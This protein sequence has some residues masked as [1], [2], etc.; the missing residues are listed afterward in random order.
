MPSRPLRPRALAALCLGGVLALAGCTMNNDDGADGSSGSGQNGGIP[1][2]DADQYAQV[3]L[4]LTS[5]VW[6]APP[7][8]TGERYGCDDLLVPIQTVP[9][10]DADRL[11]VALDFLLADRSGVHGD[12]SLVNAVAASEDT[13]TLTEHRTSGGRETVGFSGNIIV[14]GVCGAQRVRAQLQ[15]TVEAISGR[16]ASIE[17]DGVPLD[18]YLGLAPLEQGEEYTVPDPED[19]AEPTA[20]PSDAAPIEPG[21]TPTTFEPLPIETATT[22]PDW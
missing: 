5:P 4:Y 16:E 9:V 20:D 6:S 13:L 10:K 1:Q 11:A 17:I 12:P 22:A 15:R 7:G 21:D 3:T 2:P 8:A 19:D 18:D 14:D